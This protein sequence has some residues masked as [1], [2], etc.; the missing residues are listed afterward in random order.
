MATETNAQRPVA[1]NAPT[2]DVEKL[3]KSV[4]ERAEKTEGKRQADLEGAALLEAA[5]K[6]E[7]SDAVAP[8]TVARQ[9]IAQFEDNVEAQNGLPYF[10]VDDQ[11]MVSQAAMKKGNDEIKARAKEADS[12]DAGT[13]TKVAR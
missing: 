3:T 11:F 1:G 8:V 7:L 5:V 6:G 13:G 4:A 9:P 12:A 2:T 10:G